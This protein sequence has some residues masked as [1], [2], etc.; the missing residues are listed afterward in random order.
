MYPYANPQQVYEPATTP[1]RPAPPLDDPVVAA[2]HRSLVAYY[3]HYAQ[4][5]LVAP[6]TAH[7]GDS[8]RERQRF[9]RREAVEWARQCGIHVNG[10]LDEDT[11]DED[12]GVGVRRQ[13]PGDLVHGRE[14]QRTTSRPLPITPASSSS[15][16][17]AIPPQT[18]TDPR[19]PSVV[20]SRPPLPVAPDR[21]AS[22]IRPSPPTDGVAS[23]SSRSVSLSNPP[24]RS[25]DTAL[26]S[27]SVT[28]QQR[29]FSEAQARK[30]PLPVPPVGLASPPSTS[31]D[32]PNGAD[33]DDLSHRLHRSSIA[34]CPASDPS[35]PH[36]SNELFERAPSQAAPVPPPPRSPSPRRQASAPSAPE[37]IPTFSI[38]SA[39]ED[40]ASTPANP[41]IP[42]FAFDDGLGPDPGPPAPPAAPSFSFSLSSDDSDDR[43]A[44]PTT[45]TRRAPLHPRDD[46]THPSHALYHPTSVSSP[47]ASAPP[48]SSASSS[49]RFVGGTSFPRSPSTSP[50]TVSSSRSEPVLVPTG[51]EAGTVVCTACQTPIFGRVVVALEREWHPDCFVC[52]EEGCGA[53]LE[54]L[55]F[56]GT[57]EDW[58][59]ENEQGGE[60]ENDDGDGR[61]VAD[62]EKGRPANESGHTSS[63]LRGKAW[64]MVHF[65]DRFALECYHCHTPIASADYL[66]IT[67]PLLPVVPRSRSPSRS[68]PRSAA[69]ASRPGEGE[70]EGERRRA[71]APKTR[72]YHPLHFFCAGCGDPFLDPVAYERNGESVARPYWVHAGWAYCAACDLAR[73]ERCKG[74]GKGVREEEGYVEVGGE[75]DELDLDGEGDEGGNERRGD[76][77]ARGTAKAKYHENCF[78]CF[79]CSKPL[80]GI[81]LLRTPLDRGGEV[82]D[83][84]GAAGQVAA[85]GQTR[86][87]TGK[88]GQRSPEPDDRE[89]FCA[90]CF[91]IVA[92]EEATRA[93]GLS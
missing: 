17:S 70:G 72:Y 20:G 16:T 64:C 41:P 51:P 58:V 32:V 83:A 87:R 57:P 93:A 61:D 22:P 1:T 24:V 25:R 63:S 31:P 18:T 11:P 82:D 14:R 38:E 62:D 75:G 21:A 54:V 84:R 44:D 73:R 81:Y 5:G 65:E 74:C 23:P 92:K 76:R 50:R 46:P 28:T 56:E 9:A 7:R 8:E 86:P 68:A 42:T 13:G 90:G 2:H 36:A 52:A 85:A 49:S 3:W 10:P 69:S 40:P 48:A 66:P 34:G 55:E 91:D 4:Q 60:E 12:E 77:A 26:P 43:G 6:L 71:T 80:T 59:D 39:P 37:V 15:A 19:P 67:D 78:T 30:R 33:L 47:L 53:R 45:S 35:S 89:A 88:P 79:M 27:G 29:S